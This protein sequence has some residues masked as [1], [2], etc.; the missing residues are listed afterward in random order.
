MG[1]QLGWE[2]TVR[3]P[4]P[5]A[6]AAARLVRLLSFSSPSLPCSEPDAEVE[7]IIAFSRNNYYVLKASRTGA[8]EGE[9]ERE[10][11]RETVE[12]CRPFVAARSPPLRVH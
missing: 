2:L 7:R 4:P 12:A 6:A 3:D 8:L 1:E 10:S 9:G 5:L 11:G